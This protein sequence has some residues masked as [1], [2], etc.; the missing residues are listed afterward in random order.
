V[1]IEDG[2]VRRAFARTA[3]LHNLLL[4][5][6]VFAGDIFTDLPFIEA[7]FGLGYAGVAM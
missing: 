7:S 2:R 6:D 1:E 3:S 4:L 5:H